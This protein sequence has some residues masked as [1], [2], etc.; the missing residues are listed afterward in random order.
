LFVKENG[1]LLARVHENRGNILVYA[2]VRPPTA[3]EVAA[4]DALEVVQ[5]LSDTGECAGIVGR[6]C[7]TLY[8]GAGSHCSMVGEAEGGRAGVM[9]TWLGANGC[10]GS[11]KKKFVRASH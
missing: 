10:L 8:L 1:K 4:S 5:I 11:L 6:P 7:S 9:G 2:R 3:D